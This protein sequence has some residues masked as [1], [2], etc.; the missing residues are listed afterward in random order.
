MV[1]KEQ[2]KFIKSHT[3][4]RVRLATS[5][6]VPLEKFDT[7]PQLGRFTLRDEGKTIAEGTVLRYKPYST[8]AQKAVAKAVASASKQ[9]ETVT[10]SDKNKELVFDMETGKTA[11]AKA[12]MQGI[13]EGDENEGSDGKN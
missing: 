3:I 10:V 2:P 4:A 9:L 12:K 8:D 13:A 6:P 7:I 1:R 11:D 5:G